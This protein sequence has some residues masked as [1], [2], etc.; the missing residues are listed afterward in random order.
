[1]NITTPASDFRSAEFRGLLIG[2]LAT[3]LKLDPSAIDPDK[4]FDDLGLDSTDAVVVVGILEERLGIELAPELLLQHRTVN[5]V[6]EALS[7]NAGTGTPGDAGG[8]RKSARVFMIP[9]CGG[10]DEP[11]LI[12]FRAECTPPLAFELI[13]V[14]DWRKWVED[15]FTFDDLVGRVSA[16]IVERNPHG[17]IQLSG[18]SQGGQLAY[19]SALALRRSGHSVTFVGLLDTLS[20]PGITHENWNG[21]TTSG[22]KRRMKSLTDFSKLALRYLANQLR[23]GD[24]VDRAGGARTRLVLALWVLRPSASRPR[25]LLRLLARHGRPLFRGAGGVRL[26][27]AIQLRLF[28]EMWQIWCEQDK[29]APLDARVV[30]FRST[31]PGTPDFGWAGVCPQLS[32]VQIDG[33]HETMFDAEYLSDLAA[34]FTGAVMDEKGALASA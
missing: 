7:P 6:I 32:I 9:G 22:L 4:T 8:E 10:R 11:G 25:S 12:K 23:G 31:E 3:I 29:T 20:G 14:G 34:S 13:Q 30:L 33:N 28:A 27:I 17:P 24:G 21:G 1:M 18:Y 26:E 16:E 5:A 2:E 19:A 15:E